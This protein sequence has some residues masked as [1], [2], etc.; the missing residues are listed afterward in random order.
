MYE[1]MAKKLLAPLHIYNCEEDGQPKEQPDVYGK[2]QSG[3][4]VKL[5]REHTDLYRKYGEPVSSPEGSPEPQGGAPAA[6][7]PRKRGGG[8]GGGGTKTT[9]P[10][11]WNARFQDLADFVAKHGFR[12]RRTAEVDA[13]RHLHY[14]MGQQQRKLGHNELPRDQAEKL[15]QL[16]DA[17]KGKKA[18]EGGAAP[19][20]SSGSSRR[21]SQ[22]AAAAAAAAAADDDDDMD[23]QGE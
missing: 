23:E 4:P 10:E 14:W 3:E 6:P 13:E 1:E 2:E 18:T 15:Q 16:L 12:P 17:T 22:G 7:A 5:I 21:S 20:K 8:G 9:G 19:R 11:A